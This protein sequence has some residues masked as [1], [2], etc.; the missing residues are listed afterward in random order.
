MASTP[1][2]P[3]DE[4]LQLIK[5]QF[6]RLL[7]IWEK[8]TGSKVPS[9]F[10]QFA[11]DPRLIVELMN[12]KP[13]L[14]S[15]AAMSKIDKMSAVFHELIGVRNSQRA[16]IVTTASFLEAMIEVLVKGHCKL[17]KRILEGDQYTFGVRIVI[18]FEMDA[19]KSPMFERID[20]LRKLRNDAAHEIRFSVGEKEIKA[21]QSLVPDASP[22]LYQICVR[23]LLDL[24]E[25]D[26]MLFY[27]QLCPELMEFRKWFKEH[28]ETQSSHR[29]L[30]KRLAG[31]S[32]P[33]HTTWCEKKKK[34]I[35]TSRQQ[36]HCSAPALQIYSA[37]FGRV[38]EPGLRPGCFHA[39]LFGF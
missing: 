4:D 20:W 5:E 31:R 38:F 13:G 7:A 6:P 23:L 18:L 22:D 26:G 32:L 34:P 36:T 21:Y 15:L 16:L 39:L 17:R 3:T 10:H 29:K 28:S 33:R 25:T 9:V 35:Q 11:E 27:T 30:K 14:G 2:N 37:S 24:W 19:L 8:A 1:D 12:S